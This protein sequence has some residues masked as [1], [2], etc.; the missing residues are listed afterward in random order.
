MQDMNEKT[1]VDEIRLSW[2]TII[3]FETNEILIENKTSS[4]RGR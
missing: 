4:N 3:N 1:L 2:S